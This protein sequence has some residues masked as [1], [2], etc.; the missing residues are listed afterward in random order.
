MTDHNKTPDEQGV[1]E[2]GEASGPGEDVQDVAAEAQD[3]ELTVEDILSAAQDKPEDDA[4]NE[5]LN[6]LKRLTAEYANYRK[7]TEANRELERQRAVASALSVFLPVLDDLDRAEKHGDLEEGSAFR[8][9]AQKT[10]GIVTDLGLAEFGEVGEPFD[11]NHH[12]AIT[13]VPNPAVTEASVLEVFE[14][15]YRLGEVQLRAAKVVVAVPAD[16]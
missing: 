12:E 2:N 5:H 6:D 4:T 11:P 7:R 9:I 13:Q 1:P 3:D 8:T 16:G 15:G 14:K 10:R